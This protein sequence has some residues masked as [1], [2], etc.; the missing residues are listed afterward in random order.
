MTAQWLNT[1][2]LSLGMIGVVLIFIWGPPQPSFEEAVFLA[3][4]SR[5]VFT[6]GTKAADLEEAARRRKLLHRLISRI[7]LVLIFVG[8]A[9]QTVAL[10]V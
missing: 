2:G 1:I 5:T 7:G 6:D 8:F 10:W 3:A 9:F 4:D